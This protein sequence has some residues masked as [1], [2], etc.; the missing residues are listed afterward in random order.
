VPKPLLSLIIPAYNEESRLP[1]TLGA[2][3]EYLDSQSYLSE[4][5]VVENG[6]QDATFAIAQDF[7][8]R[9][10]NLHA[11][12]SEQRGKG[13]AVRM[14][15]LMAQGEYRFMCDA[16]FSMP[17][18]QIDR[19]IPP[20][21]EN[22]DI[23][24]AS[25]EAHGAVRYNEPWYRH[26]VGRIYNWMIR[27]IALPGLQDTQC[28][29]KCFR[30]EVAEDLFNLQTLNGWSFDVELL[31]IAQRRGCKIVEIG[32]PWYFNAE[33]KIRVLKDSLRMGLDLLRIRLNAL[34]GKY[35]K[36]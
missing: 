26:F 2:L 11:L 33:S 27:I 6:S 16:D 13:Q 10:P 29:F 7:A 4:V 1:Q 14:G 5:L 28:G 8:S 17:V 19:F 21:L 34:Q 30:G 23:A 20:A 18:D 9:Y 22:Y 24:I 25:R 12:H 35:D 36:N 3:M 31:F 15:M 32:I